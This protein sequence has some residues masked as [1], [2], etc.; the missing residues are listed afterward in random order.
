MTSLVAICLTVSPVI[1]FLP[2]LTVS[3]KS[4]VLLLQTKLPLRELGLPTI[5]FG[6]KYHNETS[7]GSDFIYL[8]RF[9]S[10]RKL[11]I[12]F[13]ASSLLFIAVCLVFLRVF[14]RITI[15]KLYHVI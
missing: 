14:D 10:G 7:F 9:A 12:V 11:Q 13:F 3:D 6:S 8:V 15:L 1:D 5:K 2:L 4:G